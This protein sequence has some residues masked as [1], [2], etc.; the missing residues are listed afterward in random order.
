MFKFEILRYLN[1]IK[2]KK[3]VKMVVYRVLCDK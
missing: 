3:G 1:K 2:K